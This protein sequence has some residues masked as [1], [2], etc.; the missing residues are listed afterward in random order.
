MKILVVDDE[1]LVSECLTYVLLMDG[2][3]V[4]T[5]ESGEQA[6]TKCD[7]HRFNL[8]LTDHTMPGMKGNELAERIRERPQPPPVIMVTGY[9]PKPTPPGVARVVLKPFGS[10]ELRSIVSEFD[11]GRVSLQGCSA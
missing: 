1:P 9:P 11:S 8:I 10:T 5:A 2:H 7:C 3:E 4:E 6:L